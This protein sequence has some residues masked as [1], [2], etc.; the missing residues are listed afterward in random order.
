MKP[1]TRSRSMLDSAIERLS[2]ACPKYRQSKRERVLPSWMGVVLLVFAWSTA[3]MAEPPVERTDSASVEIRELSDTGRTVWLYTPATEALRGLVVIAPAGGTLLT[4]AGLGPGDR[5]EHLPYAREGFAVVS[6]SLSGELSGEVTRGEVRSAI[7]SFAAAEAGIADARAAIRIALRELPE[8]HRKPIFAAGHS[9]A[10]NLALA[11]AAKEAT[12]RAV[13]AYAPAADAVSF[14]ANT[15]L[16]RIAGDVPGALA[17]LE[18][19]SPFELAGEITI[20]TLLFHAEDD[21]VTPIAA[22][23]ELAR[24]LEQSGTPV[25][26]VTAASG[27]HYEAMLEVGIPAALRFFAREAARAGSEATTSGD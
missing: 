16:A 26:F 19:L 18:R 14:V 23:R 9:S 5:E 22:T 27:G 17:T 20:P 7:A 6:F 1:H 3:C 15:R 8:L 10:A 25:E 21:P 11:L 24:R 2:L 4:A 13:A 12:I